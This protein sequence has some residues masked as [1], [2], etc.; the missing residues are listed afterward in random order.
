MSLRDG[1]ARSHQRQHGLT[2]LTTT[3]RRGNQHIVCAIIATLKARLRKTELKSLCVGVS[4]QRPYGNGRILS[5]IRHHT[6]G[7]PPITVRR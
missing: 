2:G 5:S 6:T 7:G 1:N 3:L 4:R